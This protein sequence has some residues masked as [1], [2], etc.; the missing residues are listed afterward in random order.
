MPIVKRQV[1]S[2]RYTGEVFFRQYFIADFLTPGNYWYEF[3]RIP[4][5]K[6][7]LS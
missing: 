5:N 7:L 3:E 4:V 1:N 2:G 6:K